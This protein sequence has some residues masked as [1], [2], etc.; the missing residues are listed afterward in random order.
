MYNLTYFF[1]L[2]L[3]IR[4]IKYPKKIDAVIPP[5]APLIPPVNAPSNPSS[6]TPFIAASASELPKLGM[7][8]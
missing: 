7:G 1:V 2:G 8:L 3:N 5:A 4:A 6:L